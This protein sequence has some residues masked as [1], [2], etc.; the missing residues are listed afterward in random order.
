MA[1]TIS[2]ITFA[3]IKKKKC[4]TLDT[5]DATGNGGIVRHLASRLRELRK[6]GLTKPVTHG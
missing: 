3:E 4:A 5:G 6:E 2:R 1:L